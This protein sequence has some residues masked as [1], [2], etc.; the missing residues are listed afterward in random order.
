MWI[1]HGE[2]HQAVM[3][4]MKSFVFKPACVK[5]AHTVESAYILGHKVCLIA[6]SFS[7]SR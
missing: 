6:N 3:L 2:H 4:L 7:V 1:T 5:R